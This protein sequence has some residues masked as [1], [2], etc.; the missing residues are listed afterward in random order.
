M[1]QTFRIF[2]FNVYNGKDN[3]NNGSESEEEEVIYGYTL[4]DNKDDYH[5]NHDNFKFNCVSS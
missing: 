2:D 5:E 4:F 1:E 3:A